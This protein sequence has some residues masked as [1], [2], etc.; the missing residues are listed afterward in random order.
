MKKSQVQ[1]KSINFFTNHEVWICQVKEKKK[2]KQWQTS[3]DD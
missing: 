1:V 3:V 2:N